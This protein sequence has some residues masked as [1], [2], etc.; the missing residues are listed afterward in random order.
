[1]AAGFNS[2]AGITTDGVSLYVTDAARNTV[3]K[4]DISTGGVSV[5]AGSGAPG[6]A[7]GSG[8]LASFNSPFGVTTDGSGLFLADVNNNTVRYIK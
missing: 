5:L 2:P 3:L 1:M 6:S 4:V 8:T 7:D